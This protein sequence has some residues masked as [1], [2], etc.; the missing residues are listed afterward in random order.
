MIIEGIATSMQDVHDLNQFGADRIEL[1]GDMDKDGLTPEMALVKE[2]VEASSIPINVMIR[3]HDLS[4]RYTDREIMQMEDQIRE[5]ASYGANGI[6]IGALAEEGRIDTN[7]LE[8]FISVHG[9]MDITFHKAFDA[10]DDHFE[11]LELLLKYPEVK[12]ILT[13]GGP[14]GVTD[15]L[16]HLE[17]LMQEAEDT[18]V[19]IMPGGGLS[20]ENVAEVIERLKPVSLHFGT[21]VRSGKSYEAGISGEKLAF[22]RSA[23]RNK[24]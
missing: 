1:C 3:P 17:R 18:H 23:G 13:S 4:F 6:V 7:A 11:G 12:T 16:E 21:G 5:V 20:T 9:N 24:R 14:G 8:N 10:L 2:A 15:N 22:I 19:T